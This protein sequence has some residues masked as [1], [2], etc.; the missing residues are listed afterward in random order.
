MYHVFS[1]YILQVNLSYEKIHTE[2]YVT[3]HSIHIVSGLW[4]LASHVVDDYCRANS[5][6]LRDIVG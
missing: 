4:P 1:K 6:L 3:Y 5:T 2:Q